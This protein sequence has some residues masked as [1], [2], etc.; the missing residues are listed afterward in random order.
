[1]A[2]D[3]MSSANGGSHGAGDEALPYPVYPR[4]VRRWWPLLVSR[5]LDKAE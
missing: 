2:E 5:K 4:I 1:M 3:G